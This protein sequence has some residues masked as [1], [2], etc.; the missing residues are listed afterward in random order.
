MCSTLYILLYR[1]EHMIIGAC[2]HIPE[3]VILTCE[4]AAQVQYLKPYIIKLEV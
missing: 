3:D 4:I 2:S 1:E